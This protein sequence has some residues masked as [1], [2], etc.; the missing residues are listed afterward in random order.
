MTK[1]Q[2][3]EERDFWLT[4]PNHRPSLEEVSQELK[5]GWNLEERAD[6]KAME[7]CCLLSCYA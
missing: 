3:E 5:Q 2:G 6:A 7:R 4:F 1:K